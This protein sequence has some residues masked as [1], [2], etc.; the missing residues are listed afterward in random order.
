[1]LDRTSHHTLLTYDDKEMFLKVIHALDAPA[2]IDILQLLAERSMLTIG[3]I[4]AELHMPM[5]TAALSVKILEEVG[6]I[7]TT[8]QPCARG[9]AKLCRIHTSQIAIQ[10]L[11]NS[12]VR[13]DCMIMD[14]PIGCF[15]SAEGITPTCGLISDTGDIGTKDTPSSFYLP[16]R[17]AAQLIWL[18][19]GYLEYRFAVP[20]QKELSSLELSF[21]AC[22]EVSMWKNPWESD[23]SVSINDVCIGTWTSPCDCGGRQGLLTPD[24]WGLT[25]TQYGIL[26]TWRVDAKGTWLDEQYLSG[27]TIDQLEI[28]AQS[29]IAVKIGVDQQSK[30][31]GGMNLFGERFGD[32]PQSIRL[33]CY[34]K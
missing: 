9:N 16:E 26:K 33:K 20:E 3:E 24:W 17:V 32:H 1:M 19:T 27:V 30:H 7:H 15:S 11:S 31:P 13:H 14:M 23:I 6:L 12:W 4:A 8:L 2:R 18:N 29:Y 34:S 21:E 28:H 10:L 25:N 5:S 22:S